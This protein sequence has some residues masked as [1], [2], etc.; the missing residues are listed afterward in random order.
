MDCRRPALELTAVNHGEGAT[1][2]TQDA[3]TNRCQTKGTGHTIT[4]LLACFAALREDVLFLD[5]HCARLG[6]NDAVV[7]PACLWREFHD[8]S[9]C[10][11]ANDMPQ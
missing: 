1:I 7:I 5:E 10:S 8:L 11:P 9:C 2:T 4:S 6:R 3:K